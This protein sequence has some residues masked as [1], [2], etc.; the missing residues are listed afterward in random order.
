MLE[1]F[2]ANAL[3][4]TVLL[5]VKRARLQVT[6]NLIT[7]LK[8]KTLKFFLCL[9]CYTSCFVFCAQLFL[10]RI[11]GYRGVILFTWTARVYDRDKETREN[12]K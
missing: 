1:N 9:T 10:H 7:A 11:F 3:K 4:V 6:Q 12:E 8:I 2:C 5:K